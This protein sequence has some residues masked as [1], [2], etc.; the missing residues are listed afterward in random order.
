MNKLDHIFE[1]SKNAKSFAGAYIKHL[2]QILSKTDTEEIS[3][4]IEILLDARKRDATIFFMGNGGSAAT[5][6][7]FA[8]DIGIG[9][10]S[11]AKPFRTISL[12]DNPAVI[13]A[14]AN[15]D[16]YENIFLKQLQMLM[17]NGDVVV[18]IS[19][20]GNSINLLKAV[21]YA[22]QN[23][24]LT[25][26]ITAFDGGE[27]KKIAQYGIHIATEAKEYGPAED[28]HMI[29]DHLVGAYLTRLINKQ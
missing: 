29:L 3:R 12:A 27:L 10:N 19:A 6:S 9:T 20:S 17:R 16:G 23:G 25:F 28:A 13:T 2:T 26:G 24:G 7:H 8:N 15:D 21:E 18:A 14:I 5:A 1:D 22:K 11:L 4:F